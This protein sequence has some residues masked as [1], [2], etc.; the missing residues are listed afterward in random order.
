MKRKRR[1]YV[2]YEDDKWKVKLEKGAVI[3]VH[4]SDYRGAVD[5]AK[6]LGR[7]NRR[8]V[9]VN[10]KSGATGSEYYSVEDL[11]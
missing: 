8:P 1:Y 9:M 7:N 6:R 2:I 4:G 3:S 10:F 5:E 11:T